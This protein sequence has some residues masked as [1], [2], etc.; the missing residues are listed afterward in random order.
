MT[1]SALVVVLLLNLWIWRILS[2]N[3]FLGLI[4]ISITLCLSVLLVKPNKKLTGILV[5]L[6]V[7]LLILQWTTTRSASLTDLSNDQIRVRDMRL[8]E[9][10]PIYFLPIAHWFEG[11]QESTA[12]F[13]LLNNFSEAVDPN[14]YFFA[15]H[16]RER[17]GVKEFEKFPYIF[18]PAFVMGILILAQKK[19]KVFFFSLL[20]PFTVLTL[21]GSDNPLGPFTLLP[22]ISVAIATGMKFF[23]DGLGKKRVIILI[24][25]ILI[26]A[27]FIQTLAYDRF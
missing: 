16:P 19:K 3:L 14:L 23:Y 24:A 7:L 18:L 2:I 17:V 10:P 5:I 8:R 26:L 4:L 1:S 6:G 20:L 21:K 25:L 9:Y 27:V 13:R 22:A 12:F 11:R 15:N